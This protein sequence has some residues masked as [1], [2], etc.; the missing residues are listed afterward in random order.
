MEVWRRKMRFGTQAMTRSPSRTSKVYR[1][2]Y[3]P[4]KNTVTI[5]PGKNPPIQDPYIKGVLEEAQKLFY[6]YR[7]SELTTAEWA[8][9]RWW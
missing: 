7:G 1:S 5:K 9:C 2:I 6:V 8:F 3:L 4:R